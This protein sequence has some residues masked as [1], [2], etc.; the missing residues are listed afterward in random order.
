MRT[1]VERVQIREHAG[2]VVPA[3]DLDGAVGEHVARVPGRR[4]RNGKTRD[5]RQQYG[6]ANPHWMSF[7][8]FCTKRLVYRSASCTFD[9]SPVARHWPSTLLSNSEV[10]LISVTSFTSAAENE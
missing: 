4:L 9:L 1:N 7:I 3:H 5:D 8:A 10:K 6:D 2:E